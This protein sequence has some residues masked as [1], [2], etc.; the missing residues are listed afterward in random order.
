MCIIIDASCASGAFGEPSPDSRPVIDWIS[1][2][3]GV[4]VYGGMLAQELLRLDKAKRWLVEARRQGRARLIESDRIERE[5]Q[6]LAAQSK[7]KS[8]DSHVLALA[9]ASGARLL[10]TADGPLSEDFT[11]PNV[12]NHPRGKVY[13]NNGHAHLLKKNTCR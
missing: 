2:G 10:Y 13:K 8:N 9:R 12:I 7:L 11:D 1:S 5:R 4:L 3:S 6:Q